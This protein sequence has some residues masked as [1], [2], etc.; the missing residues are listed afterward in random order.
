MKAGKGVKRKGGGIS[1]EQEKRHI[2]L[3]SWKKGNKIG[4]SEGTCAG[5]VLTPNSIK[6]CRKLEGVMSF[7]LC[8]PKILLNHTPRP[9]PPKVIL[10]GNRVSADVIS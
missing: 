9:Q 5:K 1:L 8:T 4:A 3:R 10:F 6:C 7:G 2:L